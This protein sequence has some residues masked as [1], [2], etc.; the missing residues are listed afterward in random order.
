VVPPSS[1]KPIP[2]KKGE[3]IYP[4]AQAS[5]DVPGPRMFFQTITARFDY[6]AVCVAGKNAGAVL[7]TYYIVTQSKGVKSPSTSI[8][9]TT[10]MSAP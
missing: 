3:T 9:D 1:V 2:S 4:P 8:I 10:Y 6:E 7:D 5:P